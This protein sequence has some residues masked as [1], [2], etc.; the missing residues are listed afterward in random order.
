MAWKSDRLARSGSAM[1]DL[2]DA[3]GR[4]VGVETVKETFDLRIAELMA[5]I[6]KHGARELR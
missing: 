2:L 6:A 4:R 5:S 1:G 3:V